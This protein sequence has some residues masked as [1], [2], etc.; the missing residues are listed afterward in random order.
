MVIAEETDC[1]HFICELDLAP[2]ETHPPK[3][4]SIAMSIQC[5]KQSW[6]LIPFQVQR[7]LLVRRCFSLDMFPLDLKINKLKRLIVLPPAQIDSL[8]RR[9]LATVDTRLYQ[10]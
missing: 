2:P 7:R 1:L 4:P 10:F 8:I 6:Y 5:T 3:D 9:G